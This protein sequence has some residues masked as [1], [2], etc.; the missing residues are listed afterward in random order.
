MYA[1]HKY[2]ITGEAIVVVFDNIRSLTI[3]NLGY[4]MKLYSFHR[5]YHIVINYILCIYHITCILIES[6]A[7]LSTIF[8]NRAGL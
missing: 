7:L 8:T 2:M 5:E 3:E 1:T 4:N 6:A